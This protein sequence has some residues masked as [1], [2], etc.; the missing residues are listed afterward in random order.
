MWA[1]TVMTHCCTLLFFLGLASFLGAS[2][3]M[4]LSAHSSPAVSHQKPSSQSAVSSQSHDSTNARFFR[5]FTATPS[6]ASGACACTRRFFAMATTDELLFAIV[7]SSADI[8]S[9]RSG[10]SSDSSA[11]RCVSLGIPVIPSADNAS[12]ASWTVPSR[13]PPCL[14]VH[15][16]QSFQCLSQINVEALPMT[17]SPALAR[18][19]ITF[20]RRQS[21]KKPTRPSSL[22]RTAL[23]MM[24][25]FSR[26]WKLSTEAISNSR[27]SI[28]TGNLSWRTL[29]SVRTCPL[30][31]VT[32]PMSLI[33]K[34]PSAMMSSM[35]FITILASASL[36]LDSPSKCSGSPH[37][38]NAAGHSG[39]SH[40]TPSGRGRLSASTP[41]FSLP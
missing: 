9:W 39:P 23:N 29:R 1:S 30:Y 34:A 37:S 2:S 40:G 24:S 3:S 32:T 17:T 31:G 5:G 20:R 11:R 27:F 41:C 7:D 15:S 6:S 19:I 33:F 16:S 26:P 22:H 18:V 4:F 12:I 8:S 38:K 21:A 13:H 25:S 35:S 14:S 10:M 36:A 28:S